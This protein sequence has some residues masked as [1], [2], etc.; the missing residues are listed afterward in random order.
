MHTHT[1]IAL[2]LLAATPAIARIVVDDSAPE[3]APQKPASM[4]PLR[5]MASRM[6]ATIRPRPGYPFMF[7]TRI[8]CTGLLLG[9]DQDSGLRWQSPEA[10]DPIAFK[11]G[12]ISQ[13]KL[14]SHKPA[15]AGSSAQRIGLTNGDELPGNIVSLDD[16]S[17]VLDTCTADAFRFHA[18]CSVA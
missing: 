6:P 16:K 7:L 14:D 8:S 11:T 4:C 18:P 3:P 1:L 5:K 13:V 9:I 10:H 2:L 12:Q 15:G 17:L